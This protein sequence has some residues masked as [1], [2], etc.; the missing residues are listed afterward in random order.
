MAMYGCSARPCV[1][2]VDALLLAAAA[3]CL[4]SDAAAQPAG[5]ARGGGAPSGDVEMADAGA[6][7]ARGGQAGGGGGGKARSGPCVRGRLD[8]VVVRLGRVHP[9]LSMQVT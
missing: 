4:S 2:D 3:L 9:G 6:E 7:G 1:A 8:W 5:G